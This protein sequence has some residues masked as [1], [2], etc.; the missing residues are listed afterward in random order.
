MNDENLNKLK[1]IKIINMDDLHFSFREINGY[2]I[3]HNFIISEREPGKSTAL[4]MEIMFKPFQRDLKTSIY[5]V[6]NA[7]EISESLITTMEEDMNK[8]L[9]TPISLDYARSQLNS[10]I[11][12][13]YVLGFHFIRII[14]L[15]I[16]LKR[17]KQAKIVNPNAI[18]FDEFII[19]P[20]KNE[21]YLKDEVF[22]FNELYT[23]MNREAKKPIKTYFC[24]NPYSKFNPYFT[25]FNVPAAKLKRGSIYKN[26][27]NTAVVQSYE[28]KKELKEMILRKNPLYEF[29][30]SYSK[31]AYDGESI[32]DSNIKLSTLQPN[33]QLKFIFYIAGKYLGI[34]Q[35]Q[36]FADLDHKYFV[37][38]I[39]NDFSARRKVF[40]FSL[41]DLI[42]R[43]ILLS[44]E[45]RE[46]FSKLKS[47]MRFR[48]I[49]FETIECYYLFEE[50]FFNL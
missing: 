23:T 7:N 36:N 34:Y 25:F 26:D 3:I 30:N 29:D 18:V 13:I 41:D 44:N 39:T 20:R 5:L 37:K 28:M 1:S 50:I 11:L 47:A 40:C 2:N 24:G 12:D 8:F 46:K 19:N 33:Y 6:R 27:T 42:D 10:G 32:L 15:S 4:E 17:I 9:D 14:A 43:T 31:F 35:N 16:K 49:E 45:E 22:T 21:K 38:E 48:T